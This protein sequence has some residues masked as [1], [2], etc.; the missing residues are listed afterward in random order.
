MRRLLFTMSISLLACAADDKGPE[1]DVPTDGKADSFAKPTDHGAI[2]FAAQQQATLAGSANYHTWTFSLSG[3]ASIHAFTSRIA[4]DKTLDTVLYLYKKNSLGTWGS[5]IARDDDGGSGAL[6]SLTKSLG[7]GDYR[8]LVK[9]HNSAVKGPFGVEVDCTGAGGAAAPVGCVFGASQDDLN[10]NVNPNLLQNKSTFTYQQYL[11]A[12]FDAVQDARVIAALHESTHT[13]VTTVAEAFAAADQN[14]IDIVHIYDLLGAREFI[15]IE[16]GAGDNPYGAIF[17]ALT[18][19]LVAGLHDSDITS[20]TALAATC[21]LH[22]NT[23]EFKADTAWVELSTKTVTQ[24]SQLAGYQA[25]N[26]LAAIKVAYTDSTSLAN[27][28]TMIDQGELAVTTYM[29]GANTV[30]LYDY[31]AGDNQYGA[32]Y[33]AGTTTLAAEIH[34]TDFYR[35]ALDE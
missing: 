10:H 32:F 7:A 2:L 3:A 23:G 28:L 6:S 22:Q 5:Y 16:Y 21:A 19:T 35:C 13:E 15:A 12:K 4:H 20:C 25:T 31:G 24:A 8:V 17:D 27:G 18:A 1:E 30:E 11:D 29:K 33:V 9:G 34:D 26:A 14:A